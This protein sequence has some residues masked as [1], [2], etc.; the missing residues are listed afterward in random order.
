MSSPSAQVQSLA[1]SY[2]VCLNLFE[3]P[4]SPLIMCA[5]VIEPGNV[6]IVDVHNRIT[7]ETVGRYRVTFEDAL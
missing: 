7:E 5:A 2:V 6:A 1:E 3:G 4:D